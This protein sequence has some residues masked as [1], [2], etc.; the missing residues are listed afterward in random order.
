MV[1]GSCAG[2]SRRER[3]RRDEAARWVVEV[4]RRETVVDAEGSSEGAG[5]WLAGCGASWVR[6]GAAV[7]LGRGREA[8][9]GEGQAGR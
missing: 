3:G 5:D 7:V 6:V 9:L 1:T 2:G 4:E 8:E